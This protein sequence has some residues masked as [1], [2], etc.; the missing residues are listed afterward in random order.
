MKLK[1]SSNRVSFRAVDP[2]HELQFTMGFPKRE[3]SP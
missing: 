3:A 2:S 1:K